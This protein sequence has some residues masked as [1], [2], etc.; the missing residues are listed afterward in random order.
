MSLLEKKA[1]GVKISSRLIKRCLKKAGLDPSVHHKPLVQLTESLKAAYQRYYQLKANHVQLRKTAL[2]N[3][4]EA[5]AIQGN[6]SKKKMIKQL[7]LREKQ[8][9]MARK[10]RFL[11]GKLRV[12]STTLVTV[13]DAEGNTIELTTKQDIEKA[14][15]KNNKDKFE[16]S[17]HTPFLQP[18]LSHLFGFKG[19]T[20]ATQSV[21]AGVF[22]PSHEISHHV[23]DL[24]EE[25]QRPP[26]IKVSQRNSMALTIDSVFLE[27]G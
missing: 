17:F 18:P 26:G 2:E 3:L 11:Q 9:S 7:Q 24:R 22:E 12:G 8:R 25:L 5:C 15:V 10:I 21:F 19:L 20:S 27:K 6:T 16:Q 14:I 4:A 13:Q 23:R 1:K